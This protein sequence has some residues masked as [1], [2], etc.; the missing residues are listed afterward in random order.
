M[1][2]DSRNVETGATDVLDA[3]GFGTSELEMKPFRDIVE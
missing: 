2:P 3:A 1:N